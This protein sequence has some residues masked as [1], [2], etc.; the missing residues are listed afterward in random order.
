[1]LL[2]EDPDAGVRIAAMSALAQFGEVGAQHVE[3]VV[4][5]LTDENRWVRKAALQAL[6]GIGD[7]AHMEHVLARLDDDSVSVRIAAL[8]VLG[9]LGA[10]ATA[11]EFAVRA[12]LLDSDPSV[13][14][15]ARIL[16]LS[17]SKSVQ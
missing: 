17:W 10:A 16:L 6:A 8:N 9:K 1:M 5:Q 15:A 13:Q 7:T 3:A 4:A 2:L 14:E 12:R 11:F